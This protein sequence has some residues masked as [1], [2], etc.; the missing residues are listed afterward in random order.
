MKNRIF[1][2]FILAMLSLGLNAQI[3]SDDFESYVTGQHL[4]QQ[5]GFP[6]TT[7]SGATGGAED[8]L[9]TEAQA[10]QGSK[11]FVIEGTNDCVLIF[12]D[13]TEGRYKIDFYIY[14]PSGKL[15]YYNLLA[16]FA[17]SNS[18]WA[19]QVFFDA[20][21]QGHMDAGAES[22]ATFTYNY[23]QWIHIEHY[24]DLDNDWAEFY[25]D[26]DYVYD[27]QWTL[28]TF[29]NPVPKRLSAA[30]F[31]AWTGNAKGTPQAYYDNLTYAVSLL[32][33]APQ[34]LTATLND[35]LVSLSWDA[36]A[37]GTPDSYYLY[38]NGHMFAT[39]TS[40]SYVD[41]LDYPGTY[42]YDVK[43]H[44]PDAGLSGFAGEVSVLL[45]GGLEREYVLV[46]IGTGTGCPY[47]PG[48]AMGADDMIA[49][50][51]PVA[52]I[53]Y[54]NYNS[55]DPFNN[56]E[57]V[58][59]TGYYGITG[60]PTAYFDGGN[61]IVGGS[62]NQSLYDS[63]HPVVM[64]RSEVAS[65]F[66]IDLNANLAVRS[67]DFDVTV[68]VTRTYNY[69]GNDVRVYLALTE[70]KIPYNWQNQNEINNTCRAMYPDAQGQQGTFGL[71]VPETFN[72]SIS[73]PDDYVV[74]NC[75]LI[76]FVQDY[77]TKEV[78]Q[79]AMVNLGDVVGIAEQGAT[80]TNIYPNPAKDFVNI[81]TASQMRHIRLYDVSGR[82][83]SDYAVDSKQIHLDVSQLQQGI[84]FLRIKTENGM[85]S[86]KI[87]VE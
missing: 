22:A 26:G 58:V 64:D 10:Q 14:I 68:N 51:D 29:G 20:G 33:D 78:L 24:V 46:E 84:Y 47:C 28:G 1:T 45:E 50:G 42:T 43:A 35:T 5:A 85:I 40:T 87:T 67:T 36:P 69:Y 75:N 16:T 30:D 55:N 82:E 65:I 72:Y 63:Y 23:D 52:V 38:K 70:S 56:D 76:A 48:A 81:E 3:F 2:F 4:A 7:W 6:W 66:D 41:S 15:G 71:N 49:N 31:Y 44:Y 73:V 77:D 18:E 19:T 83:V 17:G 79:T 80:W 53:E 59:R 32:P 37:D 74:E 57:S 54:H 61:A 86:G 13:S 9:V 12:G 8:P 21:G 39:T 60:Y 34:N 62:Y 11:S 27:W 25:V